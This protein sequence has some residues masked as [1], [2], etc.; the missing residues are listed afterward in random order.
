M[1]ALRLEA[2]N[3]AS[4]LFLLVPASRYEVCVAVIAAVKVRVDDFLRSVA[5]TLA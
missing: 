5:A 1:L 4:R 3:L 2:V